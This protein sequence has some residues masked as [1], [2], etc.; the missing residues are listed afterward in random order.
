MTPSPA[1]NSPSAG[2]RTANP[3]LSPGSPPGPAHVDTSDAGEARPPA[4]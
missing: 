4:A 2:G 1:R 3:N